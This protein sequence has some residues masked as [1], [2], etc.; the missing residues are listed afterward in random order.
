MAAVVARSLGDGDGV[1]PEKRCTSTRMD[2]RWA[3]V[4]KSHVCAIPRPSSPLAI[5]FSASFDTICLTLELAIREVRR[6]IV[7]F[8]GS[9][10]CESEEEP[11]H[12]MSS[13]ES[14]FL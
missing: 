13:D 12:R 3:Q 7:A 6:S 1:G 8:L 10:S 9:W 2:C 5:S 11:C 4:Q 14:R